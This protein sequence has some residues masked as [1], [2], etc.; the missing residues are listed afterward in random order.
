MS[1]KDQ[2]DLLL[3][4]GDLLSKILEITDMENYLAERKLKL[5]ERLEEIENG[6]EIKQDDCNMIYY[7]LET[8]RE[9]F[10]QEDIKWESS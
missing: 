5:R 7:F 6:N 10:N 3:E 8:S 9:Y 1:S 4:K 2:I